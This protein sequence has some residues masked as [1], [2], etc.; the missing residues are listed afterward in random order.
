MAVDRLWPSDA[1]STTVCACE[2][3]ASWKREI[4]LKKASPGMEIHT[5]PP[6]PL[7]S[8]GANRPH[9][10]KKIKMCGQGTP[11]KPLGCFEHRFAGLVSVVSDV[12]GWVGTD[13]HVLSTNALHT[14]IR[15]E[16]LT[17]TPGSPLEATHRNGGLD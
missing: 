13:R 15:L 4:S 14:T 7:P 1:H 2:T 6:D 12:W 11:R 17:I 3:P 8:S 9:T 5:I 16:V 10:S